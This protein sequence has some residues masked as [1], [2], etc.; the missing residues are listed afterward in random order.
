VKVLDEELGVERG[1]VVTV[2]AYTS[3]Q[4][5]VDLVH[6]KDLRRARAAAFNIIP[7]TTNAAAAIGQVLPSLDGRLDGY[8]LRV[9]VLCGSITDLT[10]VV[11]KETSVDGLNEIVRAASEASMR[12]IIRYTDAP[13]VSSD[14]I[15][16][17]HSCIFDSGNTRVIGG[18]LVKCTMWY[19]NEWG[20]ACRTVDL[21][22][23]LADY[24]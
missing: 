16:D 13:L 6:P 8:A 20:Y 18:T 9:P 7:T 5:L 2:H 19:D 17:Q 23:R 11:K 24:L 12:G 4:R 3:D 14:I 15:H 10:A 22:E 21:V 1:L